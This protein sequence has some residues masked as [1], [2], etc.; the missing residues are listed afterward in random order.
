MNR[1][2]RSQLAFPNLQWEGLSVQDQPLEVLKYAKETYG[3]NLKLACSFSTEDIVLLE[4]ISKISPDSTAFVLDTGRLHEETYQAIQQCRQR[5]PNIRFETYFPST[6]QVEKLVEV[7]G[8]FSFFESIENRKECCNIRKVEPLSRALAN[9]S[10]WVTGLRKSQSI[11]RSGLA[12]A[13]LDPAHGGIPK[14]NPLSNW[15]DDMVWDFVRQHSLP[16]NKLYDQGYASIGC[17]PCTRPINN[18]EDVRAGRWWWESPAH[19]ECGLHPLKQSGT[20]N[21]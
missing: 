17:S 5:Y 1:L 18:N 13:E 2:R 11:T 21:L 8:P 19:K 14:F 20:T 7:K 6:T 16:Y 3:G 15:T 9:A 12:F 4:L 10:A